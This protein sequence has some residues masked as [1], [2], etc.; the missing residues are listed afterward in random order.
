GV[1]SDCQLFQQLLSVRIVVVA[2]EHVLHPCWLT[3]GDP[4]QCFCF[5]Q[6]RKSISCPVL[7]SFVV[8]DAVLQ[9]EEFS[10]GSLLP[11]GD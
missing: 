2:C 8:D 11:W 7:R 3:S 5:G 1:R 9:P 10:K 6:P 4:K